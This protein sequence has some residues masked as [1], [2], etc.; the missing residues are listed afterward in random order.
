MTALLVTEHKD[1]YQLGIIEQRKNEELWGLGRKQ[2]QFCCYSL[3]WPKMLAE[4]ANAWLSIRKLL[5]C[6][7]GSS[8]GDPGPSGRGVLPARSCPVPGAPP[9]AQ[10]PGCPLLLP[11]HWLL[12]LA[13]HPPPA[14]SSP[15]TANGLGFTRKPTGGLRCNQYLPVQSRAGKHGLACWFGLACS[16]HCIWLCCLPVRKPCLGGETATM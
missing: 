7:A 5:S 2:G 14:A 16:S 6:R 10:L 9:P 12:L 3:L 1:P 15:P 11:G 13:L 8:P 4:S